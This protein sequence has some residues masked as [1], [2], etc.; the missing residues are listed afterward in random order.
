MGEQFEARVERWG[1]VETGGEASGT[2]RGRFAETG[3]G[4]GERRAA[5]QSEEVGDGQRAG[6]NE[7]SPKDMKPSGIEIGKL[8]HVIVFPAFSAIGHGR[9]SFVVSPR[10]V[11]A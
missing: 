5:V 10:F 11:G 6:G 1:T 8:P 9:A 7:V 3:G 4:R 2:V